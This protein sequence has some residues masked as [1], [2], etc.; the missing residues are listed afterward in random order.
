MVHVFRAGCDTL[1]DPRF[2][3]ESAEGWDCYIA[4][5]F[6]SPAVLRLR[7]EPGMTVEPG[8]FLLMDRFTP[9]R[10][11]AAGGDYRDDWML[12]DA[13]PSVMSHRGLPFGRPLAMEGRYPVSGLYRMIEQAFLSGSSRGV[14]ITTH[15]VEALLD[16]AVEAG[17]AEQPSSLHYPALV[18]LRRRIWQK[19]LEE[20]TMPGIA[21]QLG[22]STGHFH[23]LYRTAFGTTCMADIIKA[24]VEHAREMLQDTE[25]S[26]KEVSHLCHYASQEHFTRQFRS[27]TG[28]SPGE[29]R[30]KSRLPL[31]P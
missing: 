7:G 17:S 13:D 24:R 1:H 6:K 20:W 31:D 29:Y 2:F 23:E 26:V 5:L 14:S 9:F 15:L 4:L 21:A 30:R 25:L 16:M 8:T 19:P 18:D 10:Y 11:G 12:F 27:V 3:L 22:L 28:M